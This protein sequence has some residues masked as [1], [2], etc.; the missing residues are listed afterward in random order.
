MVKANETIFR[1]YLAMMDYFGKYLSEKYPNSN[2]IED[3]KH[4]QT[5]I[6]ERIVRMFYSL[7]LLTK[8]TMDEMSARCVLRAILDSVT[9]YS[10][11]YQR[12]DV[13]D[14]LFR[15]HL[16]TLDG[17][18][19]YKKSVIRISEDN[20]YRNKEENYCN[21]AITQIEEEL[22]LHHY[23][24]QESSSVEEIIQS[25]RWNYRSLQDPRSMKYGEMYVKVGLDSSLIEYYQGYLSQFAHGLNLSNNLIVSP[26]HMKRILYESIP[27]ADKFIQSINQ[28]FYDKEMIINFVSSDIFQTFLNSK[29]FIFDDLSEFATA[30][31][32]KDKTILI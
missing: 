32:R 17:W 13:N 19:V 27:I 11:I 6:I 1:F 20:E 28:T 8:E 15:H 29:D 25:A 12:T 16:Y 22:R 14:M 24:K 5:I 2:S 10:F 7:E 9:T 21:N 30:L 23:Y 4:Y 3:T 26:E 18:K 31:I